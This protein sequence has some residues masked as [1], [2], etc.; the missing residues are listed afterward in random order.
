MSRAAMI[1]NPTKVQLE[2]LRRQ[3][4]DAFA[5][6]GWGEPY[7]LET[8]EKDA[9]RAQTEEALA[10]TVDLVVACG[11]DGTVTACA[12][13]LA[14]TDV[15]LAILPAGTGNL[16][17]RN[18]G[19]PVD[20]EAALQ[21]A[22]HGTDRR[23]DTGV[24]NGA[25][26]MVMAGVGFDARLLADTPDKSKRRMGSLAYVASGFRNLRGR[27]RRVTVSLDHRIRT[28]RRVRSV[29]IGNVGTLQGGIPLLP[30]AEPD[31][32]LLDVAL[33]G[34][35]RLV[36]WAS[37]AAHVLD[38]RRNDL[39]GGLERRQATHVVVQ[40]EQPTLWQLDGEVIGETTRLE[41]SINPGSLLVRV[42][43]PVS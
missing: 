4:G 5:E 27:G 35:Q 3:A 30:D 38:G 25:S 20:I 19:L 1:V 32:G 36:E 43:G 34:P 18:L 22:V 10:A 2:R 16:L 39:P 26:F 11:G 24:V 21:V 41:A 7:W 14:G 31:D 29:L 37:L 33:L 42:P 15:P 17:A 8:T 23:I 40:L 12:E 28:R 9:G 6:A 13:V